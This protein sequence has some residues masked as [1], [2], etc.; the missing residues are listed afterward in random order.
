MTDQATPAGIESAE[1]FAFMCVPSYGDAETVTRDVTAQCAARDAAIRAD[2]RRKVIEE[3]AEMLVREAAS[4]AK[5]APVKY[6]LYRIIGRLRAL[7]QQ[8]DV[9]DGEATG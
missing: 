1:E 7:L 6:T 9:R 5:H 3:C 8:P 2:E 4:M